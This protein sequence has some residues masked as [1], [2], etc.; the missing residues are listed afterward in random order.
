[1]CITYIWKPWNL[2]TPYFVDKKS[3][4]ISPFL[5]AQG[6]RCVIVY[7]SAVLSSNALWVC[8]LLHKAV[9]RTA[10]APGSLYLDSCTAQRLI[11]QTHMR[12]KN[13]WGLQ[14]RAGNRRPQER[15]GFKAAI[16]YGLCFSSIKQ[17]MK[18]QFYFNYSRYF[19]NIKIPGVYEDLIHLCIACSC[20]PIWTHGGLFA[21][22]TCQE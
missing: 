2:A 6:I 8:L 12:A 18:N 10:A 21:K 13:K 17:I 7:P 14:G 9:K 20:T 3:V 19:K 5:P 11:V 4:S 15:A 1:M 22:I 16:L